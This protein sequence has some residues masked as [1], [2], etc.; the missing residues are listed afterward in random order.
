[1]NEQAENKKNTI[2][3]NINQTIKHSQFLRLTGS[4]GFALLGGVVA[5]HIDSIEI[6]FNH[7]SPLLSHVINFAK[8]A[9]GSAMI[10]QVMFSSSIDSLEQ[11]KIAKLSNAYTHFN[12]HYVLDK[13]EDWA[14]KPENV[15][16]IVKH[17]LMGLYFGQ[18]GIRQT[19]KTTQLEERYRRI[20]ESTYYYNISLIKIAQ[21]SPD[22]STIF[23]QIYD[24]DFKN[25]GLLG[26]ALFAEEPY[27][28]KAIVKGLGGKIHL[29]EEDMVYFDN[30]SYALYHADYV[31]TKEKLDFLFQR[32]NYIQLPKKLRERLLETTETSFLES[33]KENLK[34][35]EQ[36]IQSINPNETS[37]IQDIETQK[38]HDNIEKMSQAKSAPS[39]VEKTENISSLEQTISSIC[40]NQNNTFSDEMIN[41]LQLILKK[42]QSVY[43]QSTKLSIE[44]N[45]EFKNYIEVA[46]PKYLTVFSKS[47]VG[48][49]QNKEFLDT[50]DLL[51]NYLDATLKN[52]D[53]QHTNEFL[54]ADT[55]FKN[56]LSQYRRTQNQDSSTNNEIKTMKFNS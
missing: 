44:E 34:L 14:I 20:E 47:I 55:Y 53:Q 17:T 52:I 54:V 9:L 28:L 25:L 49:N 35:Y 32:E 29:T 23:K 48:H 4:I 1:M 3:G 40:N 24:A 42:A 11:E 18:T 16:S 15:E 56:K 51:N 36:E 8:D 33:Y 50:I 39:I 41:K 22:Y 31:G 43:T 21:N 19:F 27:L 2:I 12:H 45:I 38:I 6:S 37:I 7:L 30:Y 46:L 5:S 13:M 10:F 26:R